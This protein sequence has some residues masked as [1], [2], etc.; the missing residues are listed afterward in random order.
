MRDGTHA[1][2]RQ[3]KWGIRPDW[4]QVITAQ[5]NT[6]KWV[7]RVKAGITHFIGGNCMKEKELAKV[8]TAAGGKSGKNKRKDP[9]GASRVSPARDPGK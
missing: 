3:G 8:G 4:A 6:P 2:Q 1:G 9:G 5:A 7:K